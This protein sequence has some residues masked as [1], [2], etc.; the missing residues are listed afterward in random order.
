MNNFG[1]KVIWLSILILAGGI[2][3]ASAQK[4]RSPL[5]AQKSSTDT[6][7]AESN[8]TGSPIGGG[9]GYQNIIDSASADYIVST[10][11]ELLTA[12]SSAE[13][14]MLFTIADDGPGIPEENLTQLFTPFFTTKK[15][16]EGT[17]LGLYLVEEIIQEHDGC[18]TVENRE[19]EGTQFLI[20]IPVS[21]EEA[22]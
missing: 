14:V 20:W 10:K 22:V 5:S 9:R 2:M 11:S 8:P 6:F 1:L 12:V 18:I 4:C 3:E 16:G 17:G 15:E 7:G 13:Q 19:T 21:Q